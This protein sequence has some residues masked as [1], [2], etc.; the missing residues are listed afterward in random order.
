MSEALILGS[1]NPQ[2]DKRLFI[3]LAV[4]YTKTTSSEHVLTFRTIYAHNM[5]TPCSELVVFMYWTGK[6]MNNL[7]SYCGLVDPRISAFDKDLPVTT[8]FILSFKQAWESRFQVRTTK[9]FPTFFLPITK[10]FTLKFKEFKRNYNQINKT[11][12]GQQFSFSFLVLKCDS[13][14]STKKFVLCRFVKLLCE[15][16]NLKLCIVSCSLSQDPQTNSEL[17]IFTIWPIKR[18]FNLVF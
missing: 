10:R 4:Q 8:T 1:T 2:Y 7:L 9:L 15:T 6:S 14:K 17:C 16:G 11:L 5:F 12:V 18:G 13:S 3:D